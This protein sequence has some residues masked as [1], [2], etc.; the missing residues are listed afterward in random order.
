MI[1]DLNSTKLSSSKK[2]V[3]KHYNN[4][5]ITLNI[6]NMRDKAIRKLGQGIDNWMWDD[7]S[8]LLW[9]NITVITIK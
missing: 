8:P 3:T 4:K 9:D 2:V 6:I 5:Q 1:L 7:G